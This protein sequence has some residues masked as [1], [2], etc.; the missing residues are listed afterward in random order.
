MM[1]QLATRQG[2]VLPEERWQAAAP[3]APVTKTT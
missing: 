2:V 1:A 3:G